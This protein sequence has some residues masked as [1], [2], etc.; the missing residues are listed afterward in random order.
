[1][2]SSRDVLIQTNKMDEAA[3]F[4]EKILGFNVIQRDE[5]IIG[6][7]TGSFR[8]FID[9]GVSYGPVFEFF[10]PD[11]EQAKKTLVENGCRIEAEDPNVPRC[12]ISDPFGLIFNITVK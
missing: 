7:E 6:F 9:K 5:Q 10:V 11:L 8:F 3:L 4:Y 2:N 12:Y 1:M